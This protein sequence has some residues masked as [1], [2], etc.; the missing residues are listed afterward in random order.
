MTASRLEEFRLAWINL[1]QLTLDLGSMP[2]TASAMVLYLLVMLTLATYQCAV[3]YYNNY[4]LLCF[5][6]AGVIFLAQFALIHIFDTAHR[7]KDTMSTGFYE[8]LASKSWRGLPADLL[9]EHQQFLHTISTNPPEVTF[10][11]MISVKRPTYLSIMA[12]IATYL[13]VLFQL[14][15]SDENLPTKATANSTESSLDSLFS[16]KTSK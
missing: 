13:I 1:R 10:M 15:M 12:A 6:S 14:R 11:G 7:L 16:S 2:L 8:P 4:T 9:T 5:G 3:S